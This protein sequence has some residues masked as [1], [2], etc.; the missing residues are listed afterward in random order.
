MD[1][2]SQLDCPVQF[3]ASLMDADVREY[4]SGCQSLVLCAV[5]ERVVAERTGPWQRI[6]MEYLEQ[7]SS[8]T[9]TNNSISE[10]ECF[11]DI[12]QLQGEKPQCSVRTWRAVDDTLQHAA[13]CAHRDSRAPEERAVA[14]EWGVLCITLLLCYCRRWCPRRVVP[15]RQQQQQQCSTRPTTAV[16][17][18]MMLEMAATVT[19]ALAAYWE[20]P[21]LAILCSKVDSQCTWPTLRYL[22]KYL[23]MP[24]AVFE[25]A[26]WVCV[27]ALGTLQRLLARNVRRKRVHGE[28]GSAHRKNVDRHLRKN[29]LQRHP[30]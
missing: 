7:V 18:M 12:F 24:A 16:V 29:I 2:S 11:N 17:F 28:P 26:V 9:S 6:S 19:V 4:F 5:V 22:A 1:L 25:A 20:V 10:W 13:I 27:Y 3:A 8:S 30:A 23:L 21:P 14:V 15:R